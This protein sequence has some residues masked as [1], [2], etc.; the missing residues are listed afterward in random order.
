MLSS[1]QRAIIKATIPLL[2][3]GGEDLTRHFYDKL[4]GHNPEI[5]PLFNDA[6]QTSGA[7]ARALARAVLMYARNIERLDTLGPLVEQIVNKHVSL[8]VQPDHYPLVGIALLQ[9]IRE[10]LGADVA[11]DA[12]IDAWA[13]AYGQLAN[14]LI[15]AE[16]RKYAA[17]AEATG[18]WRGGRPFRIARIEPESEE[19]SSFYLEPVD[20]LAT[21]IAQ[22]GQYLGLSIALE[23]VEY[24]RNY[25]ISAA[26][27]GQGYRISVKHQ[28]GG[29]VS[30]FLHSE[31]HEGTVLQ[32]F[33][34]AGEF[35]LQ[36]STKPLLLIAGG[37]GI[38]P[39]L[40]MVSA[41][42]PSGRPIQV[43][44][45][46]RHPGVQAFA[47]WLEELAAH[48]PQLQLYFCYSQPLAGE[49]LV[50]R[51]DLLR[52]QRWLPKEPDLDAYVLGPQP[53]M[54]QVRRDLLELGVPAGQIRHE[55]FGPATDL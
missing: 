29:V 33:A 25:S 6:H 42:L 34:P 26:S 15:G 18:G 47:H 37:V 8:Q 10:V 22:P 44:H 21:S 16:E 51:L 20:G 31:A 38:T 13:A 32:V 40:P 5:R 4:L 48:H 50:S 1:D 35:V 24:R 36:E 53:F 27:S 14:I 46:T 30:R 39:L 28:P 23:G 9:S 12:V 55:F 45:C 19:I 49:A 3:T 41:A 43:I 17:Q 11:T 52:L 7:Q 2:E 54:A